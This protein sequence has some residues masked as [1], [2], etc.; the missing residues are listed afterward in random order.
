MYPAAFDAFWEAI[1]SPRT[2]GLKSDAHKA[3]EK[4]GKPPA[5]VLIPK[6][7]EYLVSLGDT[8]PKDVCRWVAARGWQEIYEPAPAQRP[9]DSRGRSP[10]TAGKDYSAGADLFKKK[11]NGS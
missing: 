5:S 9:M 1:T 4:K 6:W 2:K 10:V 7:N 8:Y 11:G 3:W